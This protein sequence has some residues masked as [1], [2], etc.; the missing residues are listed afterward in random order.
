M[1]RE[2]KIQ[3]TTAPEDSMT[4]HELLKQRR[5]IRR[6][7]DRPISLDV[8]RAIIEESTLAPSAGNGQPWKFIIVSDKEMLKSISDESKKNILA[9]IAANPDDYAKK[10][11]QMLSGESFNV[12]YNAPCLVMILGPSDLK[13]LYVDCALATGYFM[14]AAASRGLGT[15]WVN[16]GT[17]IH[18]PAMR[19]ALGIPD[20]CTI[21]APIILGYPERVPAAPKRKEPDI[22]SIVTHSYREE[23]DDR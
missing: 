1:I 21:V 18:D 9:R 12:F 20:S 2:H 19:D 14:M 7:Q 22:L 4:F 8:I 13:N 11:E 15:C 17:E 16:F 3:D 10:Y 23:Q 5:S 6:Y